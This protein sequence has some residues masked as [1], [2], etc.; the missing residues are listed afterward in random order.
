M[1]EAAPAHCSSVPQN[2]D[3]T[4]V[5]VEAAK[6]ESCPDPE[7]FTAANSYR[8]FNDSSKEG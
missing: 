3:M 4:V 8:A 2:D 5:T 1:I 6:P 7:E